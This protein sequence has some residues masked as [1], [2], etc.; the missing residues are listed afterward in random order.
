M[1][2]EVSSFKF[3]TREIL[4]NI[5]V[6]RKFFLSSCVERDQDPMLCNPLSRDC[7]QAKSFAVRSRKTRANDH[8]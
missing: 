3:R 5:H 6:T 4:F 8:D 2:V 1:K 7:Q